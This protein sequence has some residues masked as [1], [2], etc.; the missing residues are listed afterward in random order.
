MLIFDEIV[1]RTIRCQF[2]GSACAAYVI[3]YVVYIIFK[4]K[5]GIVYK[6]VRTVN[7]SVGPEF[8]VCWITDYAMMDEGEREI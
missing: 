8:L 5:S 6:I 3:C 7:A 2:F 4:C 1:R